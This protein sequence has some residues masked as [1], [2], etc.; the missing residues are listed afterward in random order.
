MFTTKTT[1]MTQS[2]DQSRKFS[3]N[4]VWS[5]YFTNANRFNIIHIQ[6]VII[7]SLIDIISSNINQQKINYEN[8][9]I[10]TRDLTLFIIRTKTLNQTKF[11]GPDWLIESCD[12]VGTYQRSIESKPHKTDQYCLTTM[13]VCNNTWNSRILP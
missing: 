3:Y 8:Q 9:P 1:T 12:R 11:V 5:V 2:S 7:I 10:T 13:T 6:Y 4:Y